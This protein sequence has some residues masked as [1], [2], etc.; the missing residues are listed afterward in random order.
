MIVNKQELRN[1]LAE[2]EDEARVLRNNV[3]IHTPELR[4][5]FALIVRLTQIVR[6]E[7]VK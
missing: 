7:I 3:N 2:I 1:S 6:E 4:A 5:P